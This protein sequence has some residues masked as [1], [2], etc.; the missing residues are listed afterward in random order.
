MSLLNQPATDPR[1]QEHLVTRI[2]QPAARYIL[3]EFRERTANGERVI[4][5][6]D[7]AAKELCPPGWR[8]HWAP[9]LR[10]FADCSVYELHVRDFRC[11]V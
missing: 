7:L 3:P 4:L 2:Q 10:S 8:E 9:S 5:V 11:G 6:N 1:A